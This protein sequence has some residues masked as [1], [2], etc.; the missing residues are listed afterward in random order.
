MIDARAPSYDQLSARSWRPAPEEECFTANPYSCWD[1][2]AAGLAADDSAGFPKL[3]VARLHPHLFPLRRTEIAADFPSF[4]APP[5]L[6]R[7]FAKAGGL[8]PLPPR[9]SR[10]FVAPGNYVGE[11]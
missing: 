11:L 10:E 7:S 8:P 4:V 1:I 2:A 5:A 6:I 9:G 3:S